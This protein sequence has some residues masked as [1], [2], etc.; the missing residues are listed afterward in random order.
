MHACAINLRSL[1]DFLS[2][3]H[4]RVRARVCVRVHVH[5]HVRVHVMLP[6]MKGWA[7]YRDMLLNDGLREGE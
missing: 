6:V 3:C 7:R 5:V 4:C 2:S 1:S